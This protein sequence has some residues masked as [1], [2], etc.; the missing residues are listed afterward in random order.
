[1]E[2]RGNFEVYGTGEKLIIKTSF[3]RKLVIDSHCPKLLKKLK[4]KGIEVKQT[5]PWYWKSA[6]NIV[7]IHNTMPHLEAFEWEK[8]DI[9]INSIQNTVNL[10]DIDLEKISYSIDTFLYAIKV[11][12]HIIKNNSD[13]EDLS[14]YKLI[15]VTHY[16][17]ENIWH[18]EY[19]KGR[20]NAKIKNERL[21]VL[22]NGSERTIIKVWLSKAKLNISELVDK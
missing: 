1:V 10:K 20:K 4:E 17:E 12:E 13:Q 14:A 15:S 19:L 7:Y 6:G 21:H 2:L 8:N 5:I 3:G 11:A 22:V 18:F 9:D 16:I